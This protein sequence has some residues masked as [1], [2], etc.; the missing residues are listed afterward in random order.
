M[1]DSQNK[2]I[3]LF[4]GVTVVFL[5]LSFF[6]SY[7]GMNLQGIV[8]TSK[9]EIYFWKVCGTVGFLIVLFIT[10]YIFRLDIS[11][12]SQRL[13]IGRL[14]TFR[15]SDGEGRER[16]YMKNILLFVFQAT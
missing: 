11:E 13:G 10:L 12:E 14:K 15:A 6:T 16:K 7:F 5:P 4:T 1:A 3:L 9:S 2:A 8:D